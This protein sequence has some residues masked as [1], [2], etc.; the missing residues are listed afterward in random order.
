MDA[1]ASSPAN[2]IWNLMDRNGPPG[3]VTVKGKR[4]RLVPEGVLIP[5]N[6]LPTY[7]TVSCHSYICTVLGQLAH[8]WERL[9]ECHLQKRLCASLSGPP[10]G[11]K[12]SVSLL[13]VL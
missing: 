4:Q 7:L 1:R 9:G 6:A 8:V 2:K 10:L 13:E 12:Y 3:I 11:L 5:G